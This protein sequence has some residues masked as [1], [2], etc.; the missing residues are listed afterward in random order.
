[1]AIYNLQIFCSK[2]SDRQKNDFFYAFSIKQKL[3]K[4]SMKL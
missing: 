3:V 2:K 4:Q 1:M